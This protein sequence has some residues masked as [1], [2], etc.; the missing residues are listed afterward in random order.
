MAT[1]ASD[2]DISVIE[3]DSF[4]VPATFLYF[5]APVINENVFLTAKIGNWQQYNL[6]PGEV[7]VYFEDS[8]SGITNINPYS[9]TDSL[10]VSLGIDPNVVITRKPTN[11]FKKINLIGNNRILDKSY[12]IHIKNNKTSAIDVLIVD[13]IPV[14]QNKD[15]KVD[16][17]DTGTSD[18]DTKKGILKWKAQINTNSSKTHYFSYA[19]KYPKYR[20]INI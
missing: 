2:G 10:T 15:I 18:Y 16:V 13:R 8:Y 4:K 6:L 12:E 20:K 19:V 17:M 5:T 1:I 7:N 14:S 11:N 3:I 9:T